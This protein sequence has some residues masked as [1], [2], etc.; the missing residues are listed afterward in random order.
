MGDPRKQRK[1]FSG[2]S[3]PWQKQ[4]LEEES[5]LM[6]EYGLK[7]KKEI[8]KAQSHLKNFA[9]LAKSLVK[10]T[11]KQAALREEELL[12]KLRSTGVLDGSGTTTDI[13]T[14]SVRNVLNRRLQTVV[15]KKGYA[16]SVSQ[17]RQFI[18]HGHI[19]VAGT[20][21]TIPSYVVRINEEDEIGFVSNSTLAD[22][23]HPERAVKDSKESE[24]PKEEASKGTPKKGAR[25]S[26]AKESSE[27]EES[28]KEE[29]AD[30]EDKE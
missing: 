2:P 19:T 5:V 18:T 22:L 27:K 10:L 23:D 9:H 12:T 4:R 16:R 6:K 20:K 25:E 28:K 15:Y 1:T 26:S 13:L 29:A 24:A 14:L 17:A 21:V 8:W 30:A 7:N 11:S 3:H